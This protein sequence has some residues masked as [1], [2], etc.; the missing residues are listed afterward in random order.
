[1]TIIFFAHPD[2]LN[3][4][5]MPRFTNMLAGGM[6]AR[7]HTVNIWSP[8][9]KA[10]RLPVPQ[11][12]KKW[13]G[14]IDQFFL[15]PRTV[16]ARLKETPTNTLFVFTDHALGPWI[17]LLAQRPHVIHCHDFLAQKSALGEIPQ[18]PTGWTGK[19]YQ[20]FIRW[21]YSKGQYFISVSQKTQDELHGFLSCSPRL[22]KVVYN[23]LNQVFVPKPKLDMR[24][25]LTKVTNINLNG[26]YI[27]HVGGNQ[28]YK[29]R[30]GVIAIYNAWRN[31]SKK[32]LPLVLI[33]QEPD[34]N[35][36]MTHQVSEFKADI[37]FLTGVS[38]AHVR[39]VYAGASVFLFPSL[40]EGFGWPIAE[41]MASGC[42][43]IT[44]KEAP[45]SEVA[46]N[47]GFYINLQ[48]DMSDMIDA[49]ATQSAQVVEQVLSM[50]TDERRMTEQ[51]GIENAQR[52]DQQKALD[53]IEQ[54]YL[55]VL[56]YSEK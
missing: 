3:H 50:S 37:H 2:F 26:G 40:A 27:L 49:W 52:F 21:G 36:K 35:L 25:K 15:F 45:M 24:R 10:F 43:V 54:I 13:L 32:K 42:P 7:G 56:E 18:N 47:A 1:M 33:G 44:T 11:V 14:Y 41:A 34:N 5:S 12:F 48:P 17:P 19:Q 22:S 38:D 39:K 51:K 20:K 8:E 29:N 31:S 30:L 53:A 6:K 46:A 23:G 4:Q 16:K 9:P 55:Q 28:W